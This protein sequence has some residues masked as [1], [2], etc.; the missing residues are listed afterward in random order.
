MFLWYSYASFLQHH[1]DDVYE[2]NM[3]RIYPFFFKKMLKAFVFNPLNQI[4]MTLKDNQL[5]F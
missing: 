2:G 5:I 1:F 3:S 4:A